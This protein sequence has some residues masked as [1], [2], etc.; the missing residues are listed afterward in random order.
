ME[1]AITQR[2]QY[3]SWVDCRKVECKPQRGSLRYS[4]Q[5]KVDRRFRGLSL[6]RLQPERRNDQRRAVSPAVSCSDNNSSALLETGSVYPFDED[7]LKRK[8]EEVKP[9]LNG[10]SMYLVGMMGSGKTTVGKLMSKVL[11]Y[12]FFD[13]D[14]LIEQA[15][16]G[17]SVAEIFVHHGENFFRGKE[18]DALK[19][20][21]SRYQVVVSTGGG[22][23]IRPINWKYMHKGISIWL[24]V[25]L[26]ALAHR[27]AAVGT[28]SRPLLH[29]ESGDAYSVAFKRL[30]AIWD[31]RGE[32]YTNANARVSLENIAAKRGYKNVSDLT[33]TEIAIEAFEQVLSFLEKEETMEIPDGDL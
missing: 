3:P 11:G 27:I 23:V 16:N 33:P 18:T 17:T 7:I 30:T 9:Y 26:E 8:A 24:D 32:A 6:A 20:L 14:T 1:A 15:M 28:D 21:S 13:C 25:P 22:A 31:E 10:R 19:K 2:I 12:T 4:Q 5:V 29:D